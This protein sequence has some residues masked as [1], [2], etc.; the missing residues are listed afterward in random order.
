MQKTDL[1]G[2]IKEANN[3][4]FYQKTPNCLLNIC[5]Q[6][7][8]R[9]YT[10]FLPYVLTSFQGRFYF[11][12]FCRGI[13]EVLSNVASHTGCC[14]ARSVNGTQKLQVSHVTDYKP[15]LNFF[16]LFFFVAIFWKHRLWLTPWRKGM[17]E[18]NL[19]AIFKNSGTLIGE[20]IGSCFLF[21]LILCF[22]LEGLNVKKWHCRRES[23]L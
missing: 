6:S 8:S 10:N 1:L 4:S 23:S 3:S 18:E 19:Y 9:Y 17:V 13:N 14:E 15:Q 7:S 2:N 12:F 5:F 22:S 16:E 20:L 11:S 21:F